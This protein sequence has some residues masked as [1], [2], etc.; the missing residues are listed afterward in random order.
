[1]QYT[2]EKELGIKSHKGI[3]YYH[4]TV[5]L[6]SERSLKKPS[7]MITSGQFFRFFCAWSVRHHLKPH[8][9]PYGPPTQLI[10]T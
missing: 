5:I 8:I 4:M 10:S 9:S 3:I 1:M 6:P 7:K 2:K